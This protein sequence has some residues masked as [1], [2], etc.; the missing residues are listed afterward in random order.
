MTD[1]ELLQRISLDPKVMVGKPVVG[2]TR[3]T[4]EYIVKLLAH[5]ATQEEILSEYDYLS[6][7]DILACLLYAAQ[8]LGGTELLPLAS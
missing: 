2:G 8:S 3:L 7:E 5:G 1:G 6:P 4:V